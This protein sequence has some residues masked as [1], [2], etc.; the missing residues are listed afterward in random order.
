MRPREHAGHGEAVDDS[1]SDE[2]SVRFDCRSKNDAVRV[3]TVLRDN[4][5]AVSHCPLTSAALP[6]NQCVEV[7]VTG[8]DA[9]ATIYY[10]T[11]YMTK[12]GCPTVRYASTRAEDTSLRRYTKET[13]ANQTLLAL[14]RLDRKT[15]AEERRAFHRASGSSTSS[16]RRTPSSP[17]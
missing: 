7:L 8:P 15:S 1:P 13:L 3:A 5:F 9:V 6:C 14:A 2:L 16:G 17:S 4:G 12:C 11:N 10:I